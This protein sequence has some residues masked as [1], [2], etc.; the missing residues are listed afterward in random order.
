VIFDE[1]ITWTLVIPK[2]ARAPNRQ[3]IFGLVKKYTVIITY[4]HAVKVVAKYGEG[5]MKSIV[6]IREIL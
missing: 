2:V 3:S 4:S 6:F 5:W 1:F